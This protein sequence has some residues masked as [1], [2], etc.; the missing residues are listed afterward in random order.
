MNGGANKLLRGQKY[1]CDKKFP[2]KKIC[3]SGAENLSV[4]QRSYFL[5]AF[6]FIITQSKYCDLFHL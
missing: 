6:V 2:F 5:I 3:F 4:T 1:F